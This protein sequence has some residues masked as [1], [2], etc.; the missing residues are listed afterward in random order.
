MNWTEFKELLIKEV[1]VTV[2]GALYR[3]IKIIDRFGKTETTDIRMFKVKTKNHHVRLIV[4]NSYDSPCV[5]A[6][7]RG[8]F[9]NWSLI[10]KKAIP[11][12]LVQDIFE[13]SC[14]KEKR[15][16]LVSKMMDLKAFW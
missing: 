8:F 12:C 14:S 1:A 2:L 10:E 7:K 9:K 5:I 3:V 16:K 15:K 11:E 6:R 4:D 13:T